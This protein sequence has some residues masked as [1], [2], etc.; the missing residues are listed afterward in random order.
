MKKIYIAGTDVFEQNSIEIGERY[1]KLCQ[2]YGFQGLYPLDNK[3]DFN[4]EKQ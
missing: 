2:K 1:V 3:I 4:Q